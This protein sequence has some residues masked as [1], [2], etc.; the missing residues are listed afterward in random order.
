[1]DKVVV[2]MP[3]FKEKDNIGKM[4][5]ALAGEEFPKINADMHLLIVNDLP[6]DGSPDD[7]TG[8]VVRKKMK[9]FKNVHILEGKKQGLGW[10]YV[11]G[12][13]H[14]MKKLK[15]DAVMEM[16]AD[17]QHPPK[18]VKPMVEAMIREYVNRDLY[19][20]EIIKQLVNTLI[21]IVARN[22]AKYL[23][24]TIDE[25]TEEKAIDLLNYIQENIYTPD[26]LKAENICEPGG[27]I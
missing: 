23:P 9:R 5:D 24:D 1:M 19:N 26:K 13:K 25:G 18:Y 12:F 2:V 21:V 10:A 14:A 4:I 8:D 22:I 27:Y 7:G 11:R 15:A 17:F 20:K 16:D 3:A 6:Q